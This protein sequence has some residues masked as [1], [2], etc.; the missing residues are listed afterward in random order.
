MILHAGLLVV[1]VFVAYLG[2]PVSRDEVSL[3]CEMSLVH[4]SRSKDVFFDCKKWDHVTEGM[5]N[6]GLAI[7]MEI[8]FLQVDTSLRKCEVKLIHAFYS[9]YVSGELVSH[10]YSWAATGRHGHPSDS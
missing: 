5:H 2:L 4:V 10:A 7:P 1:V 3:S 8:I 9:R 6:E